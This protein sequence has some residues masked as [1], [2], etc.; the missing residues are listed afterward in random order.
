MADGA[1]TTHKLKF[2]ENGA[3]PNMVVS[4]D[5]SIPRPSSAGRRPS[6]VKHEG[7]RTPTHAVPRRWGRREGGR[8]RHEADRLQGHPRPRRDADLQ[9][10]PHPADH[11]RSL[12]GLDSATYS[13]YARPG[14]RSR[15][16][17][18][19]RCGAT[20]RGSLAN[21]RQRARLARSCGTTTATSRSCRKTRR[22]ADSVV[23]AVTA[24][25]LTRLKHSG[26]FSVQLQ[27]A[28]TKQ[29]QDQPSVNG[30]GQPALPASTS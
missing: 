23:A 10:R 12:R 14:A 13:N 5:P 4:L 3:T 15:T 16:A 8:G 6:S 17:R 30:N 9:R 27:P 7:L 21:D 18:C 2:F 24:G 11:R 29:N 25:D 19:A 22:T 20:C 26:L 28:G 1:A